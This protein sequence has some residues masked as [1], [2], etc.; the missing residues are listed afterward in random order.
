[1]P[2]KNWIDIM[3]DSGKYP[4]FKRAYSEAREAGQSEFVFDEQYVLT[5]FAKYVCE[6]VD[7]CRSGK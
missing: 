5:D 6:Y 3:I 7:T 4:S 1:M 2:E